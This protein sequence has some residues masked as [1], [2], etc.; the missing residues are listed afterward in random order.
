MPLNLSMK[1]EKFVQL[2]RLGLNLIDDFGDLGLLDQYGEIGWDHAALR[3][4]DR[5]H[6][7][8]R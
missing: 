4:G 1:R 6:T 8:N 5:N 7:I 2:H 3:S